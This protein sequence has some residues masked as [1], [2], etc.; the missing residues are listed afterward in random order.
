MKRKKYWEMTADELAAATKDFDES[1]VIDNSRPLGAQE[2]KQWQRIKRRGRPTVGQGHKRISVSIERGLLREITAL[3]RK[4][5]I[6]RSRLFSQVLE[7][8]LARDGGKGQ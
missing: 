2:R 6:S 4:R 5:H 1:H 7:E 8:A 3:A